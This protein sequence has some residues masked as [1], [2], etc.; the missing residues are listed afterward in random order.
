MQKKQKNKN[1]KLYKKLK[2]R[3]KPTLERLGFPKQPYT[4]EQLEEI[5]KTITAKYIDRLESDLVNNFY[6][7]ADYISTLAVQKSFISEQ[8]DE[9]HRKIKFTED[10][11]KVNETMID[12]YEDKFEEYEKANEGLKK[13]N[14]QLI[15]N[16]EDLKR[17]LFGSFE[18]KLKDF[19]LRPD[20]K[21]DN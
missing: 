21:E 1:H 5:L 17:R 13:Q 12:K 14:T 19:A 4:T 18:R 16:V 3:V 9:L 20:K 11:K 7:I 2:L 8:R 6:L 15:L 10:L